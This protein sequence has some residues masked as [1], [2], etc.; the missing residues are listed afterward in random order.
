M[1]GVVRVL[2]VFGVIIG[3]LLV[4]A[5][6]VKLNPV[7]LPVG[8]LVDLGGGFGCCFMDGGDQAHGVLSVV[9]GG[10]V[11]RW[12]SGGFVVGLTGEFNGELSKLAGACVA[13]FLVVLAGV[14]VHYL[15]TCFCGPQ[16]LPPYPIGLLHPLP[17]LCRCRD[18]GERL[19][20][21]GFDEF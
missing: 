6:N 11:P 1:C 13:D 4:L 19:H 3:V 18:I 7:L 14:V 21:D 15:S 10:M 12:F 20:L 2:L 16:I 5:L 17:R 9:Y 8:V